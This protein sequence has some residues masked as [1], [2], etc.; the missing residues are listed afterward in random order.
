[1]TQTKEERREAQRLAK[2]RS[3]SKARADGKVE[4]DN[5]GSRNRAEYMRNYRARLK[6]ERE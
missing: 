5:R 3:R 4:T 1:M 6:A 2:Q